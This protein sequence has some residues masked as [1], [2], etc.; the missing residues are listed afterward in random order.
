MPLHRQCGINASARASF[1]IY[2][3]RQEVDMLVEGLQRAKKVF[4]L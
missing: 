4:R 3:T 1:Y 2:N